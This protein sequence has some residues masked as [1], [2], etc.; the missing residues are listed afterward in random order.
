M[1][2]TSGSRRLDR[3]LRPLVALVLIGP[4]DAA[5]LVRRWLAKRRG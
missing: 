2:G 1:I 4:T 3:V 5:N